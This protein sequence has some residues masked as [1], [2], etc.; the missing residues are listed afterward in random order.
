MVFLEG[1]DLCN[2]KIK[3]NVIDIVFW[4]LDWL[5]VRWMGGLLKI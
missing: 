3:N 5:L 4:G 1:K 2:K